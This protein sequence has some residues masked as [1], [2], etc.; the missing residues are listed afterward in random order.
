MGNQG[1]NH[2]AVPPAFGYSS[3][4]D[5]PRFNRLTMVCPIL[6]GEWG[7]DKRARRGTVLLIER[8]KGVGLALNRGLS[9]ITL[10]LLLNVRKLQT[11]ASPT[12]DKEFY[13]R[14]NPHK[15]PTHECRP[16]MQPKNLLADQNKKL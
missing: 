1:L 2:L 7:T 10:L 13:V 6:L 8:W 15:K 5:R 3:V 16:L 11:K 4:R 9:P 14:T 12:H